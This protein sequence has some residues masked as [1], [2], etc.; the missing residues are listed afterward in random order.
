MGKLY[1]Y[2]TDIVRARNI[3][4]ENF[5]AHALDAMDQGIID[6]AAAIGMVYAT[7]GLDTT[8]NAVAAVLLLFAEHPE[9]WYLVGAQ[10]DL[11]VSAIRE[12]LRLESPAQWFTRVTTEVVDFE[13]IKIPAQTRTLH[14]YGAANRD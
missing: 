14:S 12:C 10:P 1:E 2:V 9:R 11:R 4:P 7:A 5:A 8:V 6:E 13:G 3:L